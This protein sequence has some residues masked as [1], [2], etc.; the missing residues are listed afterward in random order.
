MIIGA[1]LKV[2]VKCRV[3]GV[4]TGFNRHN[5]SE[6]DNELSGFI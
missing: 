6:F 1:D 4:W 2:T 3:C 5:I